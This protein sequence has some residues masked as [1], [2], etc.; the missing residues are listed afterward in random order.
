MNDCE[1][2]T[3]TEVKRGV[4]QKLLAAMQ[5][6]M[7][8]GHGDKPLD[9]NAVG[10]ALASAE[11]EEAE[12]APEAEAAPEAD[13]L[14]VE[15]KSFM[16]ADNRTPNSGKGSKMV[17]GKPQAPKKAAPAPMPEISGKPTVETNPKKQ[18]RKGRQFV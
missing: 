18:G 14:D 1:D 7:L 3:K 10:E 5:E 4:L 16:R 9:K 15:I 17:I 2:Q 12:G 13:E 11:P 8:K 6:L